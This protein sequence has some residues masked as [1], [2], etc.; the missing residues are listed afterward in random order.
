MTGVQ[1][2]FR[3][4]TWDHAPFILGWLVSNHVVSHCI[5]RMLISQALHY[6]S[7]SIMWPFQI[8][9]RSRSNRYQLSK[10]LLSK[11]HCHGLAS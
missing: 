11:E 9:R 10:A 1:L 3:S 4:L 6:Q 8:L 2:N 7:N 5:R